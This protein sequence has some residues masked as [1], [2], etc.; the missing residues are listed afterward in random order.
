MP[1]GRQAAPASKLTFHVG[2]MFVRRNAHLSQIFE[3]AQRQLAAN[4]LTA[5]TAL[6]ADARLLTP[7][8]VQSSLPRS[9][10][11]LDAA[12]QTGGLGYS[13]LPFK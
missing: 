1:A 3:Q 12:V 13:R 2:V 8:A 11:Q 9:L 5:E 10:L 4:Q 7:L 6:S